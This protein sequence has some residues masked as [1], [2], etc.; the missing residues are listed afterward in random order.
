M[1]DAIR[2]NS[3]S[4]CGPTRVTEGEEQEGGV[5]RRAVREAEEEEGA[6]VEVERRKE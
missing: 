1:D 3:T 5:G 2:L 4:R 6:E